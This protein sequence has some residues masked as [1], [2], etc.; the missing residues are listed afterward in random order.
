MYFVTAMMHCGNDNNNYAIFSTFCI[1][2]IVDNTHEDRITIFLR[3]FTFVSL[4]EL[5]DFPEIQLRL[6]DF[7][8]INFIFQFLL[9]SDFE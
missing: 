4:M 8:R 1:C 7:G 5:F 3:L 9:A 6:I 2:L